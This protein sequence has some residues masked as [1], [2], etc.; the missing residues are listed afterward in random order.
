MNEEHAENTRSSKK[1]S[2]NK[3]TVPAKKNDFSQ[4][5]EDIKN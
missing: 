5:I 3:E 1:K 2:F 4:E